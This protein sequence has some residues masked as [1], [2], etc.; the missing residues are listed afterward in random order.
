MPVAGLGSQAYQYALSHGGV[1]PAEWLS[2]S[3]ISLFEKV[4]GSTIKDCVIY[5]KNGNKNTNQSVTD[6]ALPV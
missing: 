4:T 2:P 3:D 1:N 5:D 6:S